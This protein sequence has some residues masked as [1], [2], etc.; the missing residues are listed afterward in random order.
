MYLRSTFWLWPVETSHTLAPP[1]VPKH[2]VRPHALASMHSAWKGN[3]VL[4]P[5]CATYG[6]LHSG[7]SQTNWRGEM[8]IKRV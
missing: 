1:L 6:T 7:Q 5:T 3:S 4:W 8:G 2:T